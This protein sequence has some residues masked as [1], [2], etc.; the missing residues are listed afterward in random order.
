MAAA[1]AA[2]FKAYSQPERPW[3]QSTPAILAGIIFVAAAPIAIWTIGGLEQPLVVVLLAWGL[4]SVFPLLKKDP[5]SSRK[6]L[7]PGL[8]FALLLISRLDGVL[9]LA[10]TILCHP[11]G[12]RH[13]KQS[14]KIAFLLAILPAIFL[15]AQI[16]FRYF[17]YGEWIPNTALVKVSLSRVHLFEGIQYV[18]QG[19]LSLMPFSGFAILAFLVCIWNREQRSRCILLAVPAGVWLAYIALVGGDIFPGWRHLTPVVALMAMLNAEGLIWLQKRRQARWQNV[20]LLTLFAAS[21]SGYAYLQFT[22]EQNQRAIEERWEWDGEVIG[23]MLKQGFASQQPL[24][25][26]DPAGCLPFWSELPALDMMGLNDYH[27]PRNPPPDFGQGYIGHE[28]GDGDYVLSRQPDLV[29]FCSPSG[30]YEPCFR[31]GKEMHGTE[32]FQDLYTPVIFEG[33]FPYTHQ[34]I[35]WVSRYSPKIGI[36]QDQAR[37][38]IPA[39]LLN[40]SQAGFAYL[41]SRNGFVMDISPN[42]PASILELEIPP[43]KWEISAQASA[44]VQ[45]SM[46]RSGGEKLYLDA[47]PLPAEFIQDKDGVRPFDITLTSPGG[48]VTI[49]NLVLTKISE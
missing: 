7:L 45:A 33:R 26:V 16:A 41:D 46:A 13:H 34:S 47:V 28:L 3:F 23:L 39:Y 1:I 44:E 31:S 4:I 10:A 30:S 40:G 24:M 21:F 29:V 38:E 18:F 42:L 9:F 6:V 12:A 20:T 19:L 43:G 8:G 27:I 49:K 22:D 11:A 17:Y 35:I 2:I 36:L 15:L 37:I 32:T 25:A 14:I 48:T 5:A